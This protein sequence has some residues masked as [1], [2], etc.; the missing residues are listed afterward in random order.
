MSAKTLVGI[1][2]SVPESA[3]VL[4]HHLTF[5]LPSRGCQARVFEAYK[6]ETRKLNKE[7]AHLPATYDQY[8]AGREK[9]KS[10]RRQ[11]GIVNTEELISHLLEFHLR[12]A[13]SSS[14]NA[15]QSSVEENILTT[16]VEEYGPDLEAEATKRTDLE[17]GSSDS[18]SD[19]DL[20]PTN[21]E[22]DGGS[23]E[24]KGEHESAEQVAFRRCSTRAR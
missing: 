1:Y 20:S 18:G 2:G 6:V 12:T 8:L 4:L 24:Q 5:A 16:E 23:V 14:P 17:E 21:L 3:L 10:G 19:N 13:K 15:G 7:L 22:G 9:A 11:R